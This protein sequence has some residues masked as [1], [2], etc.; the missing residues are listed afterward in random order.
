MSTQMTVLKDKGASVESHSEDKHEIQE[1]RKLV[2]MILHKL[3][4]QKFQG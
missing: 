2:D 3:N 1:I 4:N